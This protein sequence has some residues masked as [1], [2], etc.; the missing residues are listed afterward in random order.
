MRPL[1]CLP[2]VRAVVFDFDGTLADT[3]IDFARIRARLKEFFSARRCWDEALYQRYILEMID[4]VCARLPSEESDAIRAEALQ[5]V[6]EEEME[7]CRNAQLYAGIPEALNELTTRGYRV[8]IFTRNSRVCCRLVLDRYPLPHL[9][10]MTRNDVENVKPHPQHL[11]ST[12]AVLDCPPELALVVGDHHTD[13]ETACAVGAI[14]VGVLTT[15]CPPERLVQ[16][17]ARLILDSAAQVPALL[18]LRPW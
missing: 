17:G 2:P 18:P 13:V 4:E 5:L 7:A 12:L 16:S 1:C 14:A 11:L 15:N 3:N 8:G 10:L 9:V 6:H